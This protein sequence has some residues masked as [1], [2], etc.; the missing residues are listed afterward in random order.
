[1]SLPFQLVDDGSKV[2]RLF[3]Q[4]IAIKGARSF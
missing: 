2:D 4:H 3:Q 1:M